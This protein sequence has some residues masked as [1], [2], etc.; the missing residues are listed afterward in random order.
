M[1]NIFSTTIAATLAT[2][3]IPV[4]TKPTFRLIRFFLYALLAFEPL[5]PLWEFGCPC[6]RVDLEA[7]L[8]A[9]DPFLEADPFLDPDPVLPDAPLLDADP[10]RL[11]PC[12][13]MCRKS[14]CPL[15]ILYISYHLFPYSAR[16]RGIS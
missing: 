7:E 9:P 14:Y 16:I 3:W 5:P 4:S 13:L 10:L 2:A 8:L 1:F 12:K 11:P 15:H 6:G